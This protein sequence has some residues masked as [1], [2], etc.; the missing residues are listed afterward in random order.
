MK[1]WGKMCKAIN[2]ID[3]FCD[4]RRCFASRPKKSKLFLACEVKGKEDWRRDLYIAS[5]L[6][7]V[8]FG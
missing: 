3:R 7:G 5:I 2:S 6:L 1:S 4:M 8:R